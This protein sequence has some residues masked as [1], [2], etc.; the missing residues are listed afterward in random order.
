MMHIG[1]PTTVTCFT[2]IVVFV[3]STSS[4]FSQAED[5]G[6]EN[7][8]LNCAQ[9]HGADAK[10]DGPRSV[11]LHTKVADLTLL[12]KKNNGVFDTAA[13]YR[14]IDGRGAGSKPHL[15]ADMPIWGCRHQEPAPVKRRVS[16]HY[17]LPPPVAPP[18]VEK[19]Q[20]RDMAVAA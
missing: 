19:K 15:S 9:C 3:A 11:G 18:N 8:M 20:R 12:A 10:G 7:F 1:V 2:L 4:V 17:R 6:Q 5:E 16:K 13:I 14:L